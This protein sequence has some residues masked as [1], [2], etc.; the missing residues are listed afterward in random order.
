MADSVNENPSLCAEVT[1]DAEEVTDSELVGGVYGL[2][3]S[4]MSEIV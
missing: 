3:M 2:S 1:D 4:V